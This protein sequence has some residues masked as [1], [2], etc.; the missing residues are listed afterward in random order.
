[1]RVVDHRRRPLTGR[2]QR[3]Y[4]QHGRQSD[5]LDEAFQEENDPNESSS[6]RL[7]NGESNAEASTH[8]TVDAFPFRH[9][10]FGSAAARSVLLKRRR[11][12]IE[13]QEQFV[14]SAVVDPAL[15]RNGEALP[16]IGTLLL[17]SGAID[18][19]PNAGVLSL[20]DKSGNTR[21]FGH[22]AGRRRQGQGAGLSP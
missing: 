9:G 22:S 4:R 1:M 11:E 16:P 2:E 21:D 8:A 12:R 3:L 18:A 6:I 15:D 13:E 17:S 7:K 19:A 10:G 14:G 20:F 5:K